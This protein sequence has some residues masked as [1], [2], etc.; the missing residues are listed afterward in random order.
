[1][2]CCFAQATAC[3]MVSWSGF[4]EVKYTIVECVESPVDSSSAPLEVSQFDSFWTLMLL[5]GTR[6][7]FG[8]QAS[9]AA[10]DPQIALQFWL[11]RVQLE[12]NSKQPS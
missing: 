4:L 7:A 5:H 11:R 8:L 1:M 12:L 3:E 2:S 6:V 9:P 10:H